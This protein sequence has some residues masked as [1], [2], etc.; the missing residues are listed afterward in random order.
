MAYQ[1]N[2]Y[3]LGENSSSH[4][5]LLTGEE[6]RAILKTVEFVFPRAS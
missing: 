5:F 2:L 4:I 1:T 6:L 3:V